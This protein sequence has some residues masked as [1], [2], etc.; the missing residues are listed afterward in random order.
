MVLGMIGMGVVFLTTGKVKSVIFDLHEKEILIRKR[1]L[2]CHCKT[3]TKYEMS[4]LCD[5][6]AVWRG[7]HTSSINTLHYCIILEFDL[8]RI[9][10]KEQE[11]LR[12][13]TDSIQNSQTKKVVDSGL[14]TSLSDELSD[15]ENAYLTSD[16]EQEIIN[17]AVNEAQ[18]E[19]YQR[20][21][22]ENETNE[23]DDSHGPQSQDNSKGYECSNQRITTSDG[24]ETKSIKSKD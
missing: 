23:S 11:L 17:F 12:T 6:R 8:D 3:I 21:R 1:T 10:Q 19:E 15:N 5:V 24:Q 4:D 7:I 20:Q 13:K 22:D 18:Y 9:V 16:A 14:T 2:T